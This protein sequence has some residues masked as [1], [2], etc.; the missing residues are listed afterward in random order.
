[1]LAQAAGAV[2]FRLR[3]E[4]TKTP[5]KGTSNSKLPRFG[6]PWQVGSR[7]RKLIGVL[8]KV[9]VFSAIDEPELGHLAERFCQLAISEDQLIFRQGDP[10]DALYVLGEGAVTLYRDQWGKPLQLLGRFQA[11][12]CFGEQGLLDGMPRSSSAR[13][14]ATSRILRIGK[15]D[16]LTCFEDH[17][18]LELKLQ[19]SLRAGTP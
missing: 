12:S 19:V 17:P 7:T 4:P 5:I 18:V 15:N 11:G 16:L 3:P 9:D 6:E 14:S 13:T 8:K 1:M 10:A 2:S